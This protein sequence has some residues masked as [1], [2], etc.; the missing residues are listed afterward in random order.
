MMFKSVTSLSSM[1][2]LSAIWRSQKM[3]QVTAAD[4]VA[5]QALVQE[6]LLQENKEGVSWG[7]GR[8]K[9]TSTVF[10]LVVLHMFF[11]SILKLD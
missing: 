6:L 5:M 10:W 7:F 11:C 9:E 3:S 1:A 2:L 8:N 4:S